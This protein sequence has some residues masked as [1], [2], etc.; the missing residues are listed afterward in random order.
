ESALPAPTITQISPDGADAGSGALVLTVS[1]SDFDSES[2][3]RWNGSARDTSFV[4][5]SQLQASITSTDIAESGS[6]YVTVLRAS[7]GEVS[8]A[9]TFAV[10]AI[11][12]EPDFV[13]TFDRSDSE[14]IGN[15]WLEKSAA[16]FDLVAGGAAKVASGGGDYRN[17]VVYRPANENLLD[18]EAAA[19]L[20][21]SSLAVGYPQVL[22][23]IQTSTV[24][25][26]NMLD[27]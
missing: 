27:A 19:E 24:A 6:A 11:T 14:D 3:V 13:E 20:T 12:V 7:D 8:G 16:A 10:S 26:V 17:N 9:V 15:G 5:T 23:R 4:S 2:V 18:V 1:G 21:F 22:V 25:N